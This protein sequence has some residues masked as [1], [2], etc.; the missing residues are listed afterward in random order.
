[1]TMLG[2]EGTKMAARWVARAWSI[3]G[4]LFVLAFVVGESMGGSSPLPTLQDWV[5]LALWPIGVGVGL[6]VAWYR[7]KL[8]GI[9]AV[10]CLAVFY[11]WNL[12]RFGYLPQGPYFCLVAAPGLL[13][14]ILGLLSE[15]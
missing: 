1:M 7:E 3:L 12:L 14:L 8:G 11:A 2:L 5:G 13:F 9:L 4:I 15:R 6:V 10:G